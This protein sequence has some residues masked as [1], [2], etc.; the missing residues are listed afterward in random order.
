LSW[1]TYA[2]FSVPI[3]TFVPIGAPPPEFMRVF[4][5]SS[6]RFPMERL[7]MRSIDSR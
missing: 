6:A 4:A 2:P 1:A 5:L 7:A 3:G